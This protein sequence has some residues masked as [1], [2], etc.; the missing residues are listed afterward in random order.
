MN[1][2]PFQTFTTSLAKANKAKNGD[3][4]RCQVWEETTQTLAVMVLADGVGS[5]PCDY[6][7]SATAVDA[8]LT[9]FGDNPD[10]TNIKARMQAAA[11]HANQRV[12][13]TS[14]A[15]QGMMATFV[16]VVWQ[17]ETSL[18][19]FTSVGDSRLYLQHKGTLTQLTQD[20]SIEKTETVG[21]QT[22]SRSYITEALGAGVV[23]FDIQTQPFLPGDACWLMS[24][25]FYPVVPAPALIQLW[26]YT[27][28]AHGA[29]QVFKQ[30]MPQ[31]QD[32]ASVV[33]L[34]RNDAPKSFATAFDQWKIERVTQTLPANMQ[35]SVLTCTIFEATHYSL[36]KATT[37][38]ALRWLQVL[39][40]LTIVP[41]LVTVESLLQA[42]G[43]AKLNDQEVYKKI[44]KLLA[45]ASQK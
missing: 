27:N 15:C 32:D 23:H 24:D 9:H 2:P 6:K 3:A 44:R 4:C 30:Y 26:R 11:Y 29:E 20:D 37:K 33:A 40:E 34:R 16:A 31:Y 21:G 12:H 18:L 5:K 17:V 43:K 42:F 38:E 22:Y 36:L 7:A 8:F 41:D 45:K 35:I 39:D 10:Q 13:Q 1:I 28:F 25:G 19:Y 14:A